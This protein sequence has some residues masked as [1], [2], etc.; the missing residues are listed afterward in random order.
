LAQT[1][2]FFRT[3]F[4][5]VTSIDGTKSRWFMQ[6]VALEAVHQNLKALMEFS[7]DFFFNMSEERPCK[8]QHMNLNRFAFK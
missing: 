2:F 7:R 1:T 3:L 8:M 4:E 5:N 6:D